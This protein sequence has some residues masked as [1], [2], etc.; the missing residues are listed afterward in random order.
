LRLIPVPKTDSSFSQQ[1][2]LFYPEEILTK[3]AATNG[4]ITHRS[5]EETE[6]HQLEI[7]RKE[8]KQ[9]ILQ[10]AEKYTK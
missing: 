6:N 7:L 2:L 9:L 4:A 5:W 10:E 1:A 8:L 3:E